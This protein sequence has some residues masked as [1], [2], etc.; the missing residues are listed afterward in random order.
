MKCTAAFFSALMLSREVAAVVDKW[1]PEGFDWSR[2]PSHEGTLHQN[3]SATGPTTRE[4]VVYAAERH[5]MTE[6]EAS[7]AEHI[8]ISAAIGWAVAR[9]VSIVLGAG[10]VASTIGGCVSAIKDST[11][12]NWSLCTL[13]LA[14]T[15]GSFGYAKSGDKVLKA[16]KT[17][18]Y[19]KDKWIP[20]GLDDIEMDIFSK[21]HAWKRELDAGLESR[22]LMEDEHYNQMAHNYFTHNLIR[23]AGY[24]DVEFLGYEDEKHQLSKR[25]T[26]IHPLV[27]RFRF[28]HHKY[29][30][31]VMATKETNSTH[32]ITLHPEDSD[33]K[34]A[35][36]DA[37]FRKERLSDHLMEGRFDKEASEA[38]SAHLSATARGSF[39]LV[40]DSLE[41]FVND[42]GLTQWPSKGTIDMQM[43]DNT[44]KMTFGY[45]SIG[46]FDDHSTDPQFGDLK[47]HPPLTGGMDC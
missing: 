43:Y 30:P 44:N 17:K 11:A 33:P 4:L 23:D 45:G 27:P 25:S 22:S 39:D 6:L 42:Q 13:G 47:P 36:R 7:S 2:I 32:H 12:K 35:L 3:V 29:G 14:A 38:D 20:T 24:S 8:A 40:Y 46:I 28:T 5:N 15:I 37:E 18:I 26:E 31:L 9:P 1:T 21:R 34:L 41:C 19:S 10:G 16:L